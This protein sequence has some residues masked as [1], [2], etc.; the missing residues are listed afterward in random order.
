MARLEGLAAQAAVFLSELIVMKTAHSE[1]STKYSTGL[2]CLYAA[3][4]APLLP[5]SDRKIGNPT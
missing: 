4:A 2:A 5:G 3:Q 1:E